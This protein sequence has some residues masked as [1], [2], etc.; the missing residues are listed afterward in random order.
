VRERFAVDLGCGT[1]RDTVEL[2][3]RGWTV[4]AIDGEAEALDRLRRREDLPSD[5]SDRLRAVRSSFQEAA[6]PDADLVNSSFALPFCP[7]T[8]FPGLWRRIEGSLRPGGRFS[9]HLFGDRD[10]WSGE[11]EM[12]FRTRGQ[13]EGLLASLEVER[14]DE[15]EEDGKTATGKDKHWHLFHIVARRR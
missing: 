15:I 9:G 11:E 7:P 2:L 5:S 13:V 1:G 8:A 3:R 12:T 10:G 6:W 14:L 4:L